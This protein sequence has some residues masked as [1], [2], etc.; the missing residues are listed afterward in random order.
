MLLGVTVRT[1]GLAGQRL[2][3]TIVSSQPEVDIGAAFVVPAACPA[4]TV[5]LGIGEQRLAVFYVLCYTVH[6]A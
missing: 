2:Q 5:F 6:E 4:Y 3:R 1:S